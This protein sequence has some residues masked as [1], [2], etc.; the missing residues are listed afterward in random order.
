[1]FSSSQARLTYKGILVFYRA[2]NLGY[3]FLFI[4]WLCLCYYMLYVHYLCESFSICLFTIM[5]FLVLICTYMQCL[6]RAILVFPLYISFHHILRDSIYAMITYITLLS[7]RMHV[8][9]FLFISHAFND[10]CHVYM[11]TFNYFFYLY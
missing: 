6:K 1:M 9:S 2:T 5:Y 7:L 3:I 4:W 11:L 10:I 8:C